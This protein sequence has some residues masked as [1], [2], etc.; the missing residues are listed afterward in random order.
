VESGYILTEIGQAYIIPR[1]MQD[2]PCPNK[3]N[4]WQLAAENGRLDGELMLAEMPRLA[5]LN[6][7]EGQ[8]SVSLTA[9]LDEQGVRF[10]KGRL[11]T[12]VELVCQRCLGPLR[13][14]LDVTV[15]LGLIRAEAEANR[16]PGEY[17]PLLAPE[18]GIALADLVEDELLLALPQIPRHE[19]LRECEVNGY[20]APGSVTPGAERRQPFAVLASLLQD[21]NRSN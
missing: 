2:P 6:R 17:E 13:L 9:G 8:V 21:S 12:N 5:V 15:G 19:D 3:I 1:L 20:A 16:L 4:P 18:H 7:A 10:I 11:R 14:P